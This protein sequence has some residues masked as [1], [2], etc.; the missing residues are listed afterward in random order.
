VVSDPSKACRGGSDS[1]RWKLF[2][3]NAIGGS[4]P[5]SYA[6]R[7]AVFLSKTSVFSAQSTSLRRDG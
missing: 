1:C 5:T 4:K 2:G 3:A 6:I 7:D